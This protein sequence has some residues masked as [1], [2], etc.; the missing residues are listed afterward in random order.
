MLT[1]LKSK[2]I[3]DRLVK[4][5]CYITGLHLEQDITELPGGQIKKLT[6]LKEE[7]EKPRANKYINYF[8]NMYALYHSVS[9]LS[10]K[11]GEQIAVLK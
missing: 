6:Q 2:R 8:L 11:N 1:K 5:H 10:W 9:D 4:G 7:K 3:Q